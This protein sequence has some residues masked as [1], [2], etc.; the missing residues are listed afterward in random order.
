MLMF[1][2]L[3]ET[4]LIF[5]F[6]NHEQ[7]RVLTTTSKRLVVSREEWVLIRL[8]LQVPTGQLMGLRPDRWVAT[9]FTGTVT[10]LS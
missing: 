9:S 4:R 5:F 7:T 3:I 6:L 8:A 10:P 2:K 1:S